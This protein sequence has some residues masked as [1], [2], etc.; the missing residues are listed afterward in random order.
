M[1]LKLFGKKHRLFKIHDLKSI[2]FTF[3][4]PVPAKVD[5]TSQNHS[6]EAFRRAAFKMKFSPSPFLRH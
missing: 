3:P 4:T 5:D 2:K 6:G 1:R